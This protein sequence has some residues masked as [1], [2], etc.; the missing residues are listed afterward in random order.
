MLNL[1]SEPK[2]GGSR[3]KIVSRK[4]WRVYGMSG[5]LSRADGGLVNIQGG[6]DTPGF[7]A[8]VLDCVCYNDRVCLLFNEQRIRC[9]M[10]VSHLLNEKEKA[11]C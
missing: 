4:D 2:N 1:P 8:V 9:Q 3:I 10:I 5:V 11:A 7:C 6:S